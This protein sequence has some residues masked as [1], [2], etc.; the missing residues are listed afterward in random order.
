MKTWI[1]KNKKIV[2][3]LSLWF[4]CMIS[5]AHYLIQTVGS[6][7]EVVISDHAIPNAVFSKELWIISIIM[8][9]VGIAAIL[10]VKKYLNVR[11]PEKIF[12]VLYIIL[13]LGYGIALPAY[14]A[15][16]EVAH[17][18]RAYEI[19]KGI[20]ITEAKEVDGNIYVGHDFPKDLIPVEYME[21]M[22]SGQASLHIVKQYMNTSI[23]E[24]N[25]RYYGYIGSALYA[26]VSYLPQALGIFVFSLFTSKALLLFYA[27]RLFN[28]LAVGIIC[29][30]SIKKIP[31]GKNIAIAIA[32]IPMALH[33]AV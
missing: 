4:L 15:P 11:K 13:A 8:L 18:L 14:K 27:S 2:L 9:L 3:L 33:Q 20:L 17:F 6:K 32:L 19:S 5:I 12:L 28:C 29:Y 31:I 21:K 23:G 24:E 25:D 7:R 22:D 1:K 26:P 30:Y 16:D 10:L